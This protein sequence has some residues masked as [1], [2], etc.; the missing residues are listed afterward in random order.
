[1]A[2]LKWLVRSM[3]VTPTFKLNTALWEFGD[4]HFEVPGP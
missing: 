4:L 3:A 2:A 1:M